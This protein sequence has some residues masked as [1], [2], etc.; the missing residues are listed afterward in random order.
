MQTQTRR[1]TYH[2]L[3]Q[4]DRDRMEALL[5]SG[6]QQTEIARILKVDKGTISRE[7]K[8]RKLCGGRYDADRAQ[9]KANIK[10]SNSKYQGMK[11]EKHPE[12]GEFIIGKLKHHRSPDEIAGRMKKEKRVIRIG[13][14]A[15][16]KWIYSSY[17]KDYGKYLCTKRYKKKPRKQPPTQRVMIPNATSISERFMGANNKTRYKHFD[18]DTAVS[19]KKSGST[20][21]LAVAVERKVNLIVGTKIPNLKPQEMQNA[22]QCMQGQVNMRSLSMDRGIENRSHQSWGVP[23]FFC[24]PHSPWQKPHV[25]CSIGLLRRWF[26]PKKTNLA[27]VSEEELQRYIWILNN[28]YRKSLGY[29]SAYE[30]ALEHGIIKQGFNTAGVALH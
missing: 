12:L 2:H 23:T 14:N 29:R 27:D 5:S 10:R 22:I 13:A 1:K 24:D 15:I 8:K 11:I 20:A 26:I 21:S 30:A 4:S 3:D 16:Y 7:I 28:K 18:G 25:E 6:H 17:G 9:M 19:P